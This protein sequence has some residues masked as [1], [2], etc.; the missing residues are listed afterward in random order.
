MSAVAV[1]T[2]RTV[3]DIV[4]FLLDRIEDQERLIKRAN[5]AKDD[6][7]SPPDQDARTAQLHAEVHSKRRIIGTAQQLL[8]LRDLPNE[9][10]VREAAA[11]IIK[12][13]ALPYAGHPAYREEWRASQRL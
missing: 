5:G 1:S 11:Q 9:K 4:R 8:V 12:E 10:V 7:G 3:Q 2:A 6:A 13:L